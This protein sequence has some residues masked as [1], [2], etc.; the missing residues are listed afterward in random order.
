MIGNMLLFSYLSIRNISEIIFNFLEDKSN[1][2]ILDND[3]LKL[4][5]C[6]FNQRLSLISECPKTIKVND[7]LI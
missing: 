4:Q 1:H 3:A 6:F 7:L 2:S 5:D